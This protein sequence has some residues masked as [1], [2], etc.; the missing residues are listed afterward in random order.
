MVLSLSSARFL[1]CSQSF[2]DRAGWSRENIIG[3]VFHG[4]WSVLNG[5]CPLPSVHYDF[6]DRPPMRTQEGTIVPAPFFSDQLAGTK[7]EIGRLWRGE[8]EYVTCVFR[9]FFSM[10]SYEVRVR[11]WLGQGGQEVDVPDSSPDSVLGSSGSSSSAGLDHDLQ[12]MMQVK[13]RKRKMPLEL[14]MATSSI[15]IVE[16]S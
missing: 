11:C 7:K 2:L 16:M 8:A 10:G 14:V 3:K 15:D 6:A 9:M 13:T 4:V 12:R 1:D 5:L